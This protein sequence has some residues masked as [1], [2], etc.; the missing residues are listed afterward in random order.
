MLKKIHTVIVV[1]SCICFLPQFAASQT[2]AELVQEGMNYFHEGEYSTALEYFNDALEIK[3]LIQRDLQI[4]SIADESDLVINMDYN[5]GTEKKLYVGTSPKQYVQV[6][7]REFTETSPTYL[8]PEPFHFQEPNKSVIYN[9]RARAYLKM[10]MLEKAYEDFDR[11]LFLDPLQ[12]EIYFRRAVAYQEAMGVDVCAELKKAM[13]MGFV[14]AKIYHNM[15][16]S[17]H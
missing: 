2:I 13:E 9:Y 1:I 8:V 17:K 3:A 7:K 10:G 4:A 15:L 14:S 16:C 5:I 6:F 11:V 12:S